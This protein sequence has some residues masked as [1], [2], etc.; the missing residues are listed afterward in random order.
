MAEELV[1][2][3]GKEL[4]RVGLIRQVLE[5]SIT[6]QQ[7]AERLGRSVRQVK[8]LCRRLREEKAG[9]MASKRRGRPSNNQLDA[10]VREE[11]LRLVRDRYT[12]FGPTLAHE[13]LV[14]EHHLDLGRETLRQLMIAHGLWKAR[15][16]RKANPHPRRERRPRRGELLQ[17]DGS[18][19]LWLEGRAE[20]FSLLIAVDDATGEILSALFVPVESAMGYLQMMNHLVLTH[21]RPLALYSDRHSI[22]RHTTVAGNTDPSR[23][24]TQF[25]R[26]MEELDCEL[27]C[28]HSPQA[29]GRVERAFGVLQDRLVKELRLQEVNTM[30]EANAF[31]PTFLTA[32]NRKF[33]VEP[34]SPTAAFRPLTS[35]ERDQL[36]FIMCWREERTLSKTLTLQ[37]DSQQL[38]IVTNRPEYALR[39]KKVEVSRLLDGS[40]VVR[41]REQSLYF[42]VVALAQR[43]ARVA[44]A[45]E[46]EAAQLGATR[47]PQRISRKSAPPA[48]K[49]SIS[50]NF[51]SHNPP[52]G[53]G[54]LSPRVR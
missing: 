9:G 2:L 22:F 36:P 27:I 1:T 38:Q 16:L 31:L 21:G 30:E 41:H 19:H 6:Q 10:V 54:S 52:V 35:S 3:S 39:G 45:K 44:D 20:R 46:L 18:P 24:I 11:A 29:K 23:T 32:Y 17:I 26:A 14:E 40:L 51:L 5:G 43:Q 12:N 42:Q 53:G 15:R 13:K 33:A 49:A 8:R 25:G 7:A 4:E 48:F 28:A 37:H 50:S 47:R 34:A